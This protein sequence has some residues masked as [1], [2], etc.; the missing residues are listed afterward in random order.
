MGS[1]R[2]L[3]SSQNGAWSSEKVSFLRKGEAILIVVVTK[4]KVVN[5]TSKVAVTKAKD[6]LTKA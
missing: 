4:A 6:G 5:Q 2:G 3:C 1:G